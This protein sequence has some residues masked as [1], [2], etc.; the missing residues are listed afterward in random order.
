ME[1]SEMLKAVCNSKSSW[2]DL[3]PVT[4]ATFSPDSE[5][6]GLPNSKSENGGQQGDVPIPGHYSLAMHPDLVWVNEQLAPH[7]GGMKGQM[8]D[9]YA[10]GKL[11]DVLP[12]LKEYGQRIAARKAGVLRPDKCK[13]YHR[14]PQAVREYMSEHPEFTEFNTLSCTENADPATETLLF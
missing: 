11:E 8:D 14:D 13:I 2:R 6:L 1:R 12:V 10:Y 9:T 7:G 3:G 5:I 4:W